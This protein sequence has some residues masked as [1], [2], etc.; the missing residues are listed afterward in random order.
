MKKKDNVIHVNFKSPRKRKKPE[1]DEDFNFFQKFPTKQ[2]L[3]PNVIDYLY[4]WTVRAVALLVILILSL[5]FI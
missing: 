5:L 4:P 3:E 2:D 1:V